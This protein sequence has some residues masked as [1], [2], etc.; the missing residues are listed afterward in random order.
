MKARGKASDKLR[1]AMEGMEVGEEFMAEGN[2]LEVN[3]D[4]A[5]A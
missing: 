1:T 2:M 4:D 3:E 5:A